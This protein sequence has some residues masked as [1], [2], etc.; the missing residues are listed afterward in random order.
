MRFP[1][2]KR[3]PS[4]ISADGD[5]TSK[6]SVKE[7]PKNEAPVEKVTA[8][9]AEGGRW[10]SELGVEGRP[11]RYF[12]S[13]QF[14]LTPGSVVDDKVCYDSLMEFAQTLKKKNEQVVRIVYGILD[15]NLRIATPGRAL[16]DLIQLSSIPQ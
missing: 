2:F 9:D 13:Y 4:K 3:K 15:G 7:E 6:V 10:V 5:K 12:V 11:E 16:R 8:E 1:S 14:S